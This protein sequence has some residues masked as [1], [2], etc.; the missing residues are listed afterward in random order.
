MAADVGVVMVSAWSVSF[1][2]ALK[3][4]TAEGTVITKALGSAGRVLDGPQAELV[5]GAAATRLAVE[6]K[7]VKL[8]E[9]ALNCLH[10]ITNHHH[11]IA[12]LAFALHT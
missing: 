12:A 1:Q 2:I 9:A 4:A 11:P 8:V 7:H 3:G 5:P 6:T 10:V